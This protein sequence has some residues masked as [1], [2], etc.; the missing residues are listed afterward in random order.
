[1]ASHLEAEVRRRWADVA[2][3]ADAYGL[4]PYALWLGGSSPSVRTTP[5]SKFNSVIREES[6]K[7]VVIIL[8]VSLLV[9]MSGILKAG[10]GVALS[11][12]EIRTLVE[13]LQS[14][15]PQKANEAADKLEEIGP[16]IVP[17]LLEKLKSLPRWDSK[18]GDIN[19]IIAKIRQLWWPIISIA[20]E[21]NLPALSQYCLKT[22]NYPIEE[23][24]ICRTYQNIGKPSVPYLLDLCRKDLSRVDEQAIEAL[25][26]IGDEDALR[27]VKELINK[28]QKYK[29][30]Y[31]EYLYEQIEFYQKLYK[32]WEKLEKE[33]QK[34][35]ELK[36]PPKQQKSSL[37]IKKLDTVMRGSW[38]TTMGPGPSSVKV[39]PDGKKIL[40]PSAGGKGYEIYLMDINGENKRTLVPD[41]DLKHLL[42]PV[43]SFDGQKV[44]FLEKDSREKKPSLYVINA[45]G[46][47]LTK[48]VDHVAR[49]ITP[50]WT[51]DNKKVVYGSTSNKD[52]KIDVC[53]I[54]IQDLKSEILFS[55]EGPFYNLSCSPKGKCVVFL[56]TETLAE[57][58][59]GLM[60]DYKVGVG[61][62]NM[63]TREIE[64]IPLYNNKP[65]N[66]MMFF[67]L[68]AG[69][70]IKW[71]NDSKLIAAMSVVDIKKKEARCLHYTP[72]QFAELAD[73]RNLLGTALSKDKMQILFNKEDGLYVMNLADYS[74]RK[75]SDHN[76]FIRWWNS[77]N[78]E[79]IVLDL[80]SDEEMI[81]G[82]IKLN[83]IR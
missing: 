31:K 66:A 76:A 40:F 43:W 37:E 9:F 54:D 25:V 12:D 81:I 58:L 74:V 53:M 3:L 52:K 1:M 65:Q 17:Y 63:E 13:E 45:D 39:S 44:A 60:S 49:T 11:S 67:A 26:K 47:R 48:I 29:E 6:M 7:K 32:D 14:F 15:N 75:V 79:V 33:K 34:S 20:D 23:D 41:P 28:S 50:C 78:N 56:W 69:E 21:S 2:E 42:S 38:H 82:R 22:K 70:E 59:E 8:T 18:S 71:I 68:A 61:I 24:C 30:R 73:I 64:G 72:N 55:L 77:V 62:F 10:T 51:K 27:E 4:G 83:G 16:S 57:G 19:E 35:V 5:Q 46:T 36:P 80:T